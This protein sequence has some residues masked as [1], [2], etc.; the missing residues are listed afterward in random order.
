M[1]SKSLRKSY[2][3]G[4]AQGQL[5]GRRRERRMERDGGSRKGKI[6]ADRSLRRRKA[7]LKQ[8][9]SCTKSEYRAGEYENK[10]CMHPE[11]RHG[12]RLTKRGQFPC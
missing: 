5:S 2:I 12:D 1:V 9:M 7:E 10:E 3:R 4:V 11:A 6:N 8:Q